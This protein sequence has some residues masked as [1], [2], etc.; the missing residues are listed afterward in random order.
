MTDISTIKGLDT[1]AAEF[2]GRSLEHYLKE[3]TEPTFHPS[4]IGCWFLAY[5]RVTEDVVVIDGDTTVAELSQILTGVRQADPYE[6]WLKELNQLFLK[7]FGLGYD[8]FPDYMWH[9]EYEGDCTPEDSFA[10]WLAQ[11]NEGVDA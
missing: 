4:V 5:N 10:E 6:Q 11:T 7:R 9:D 3:Y 1:R 8:D 2:I